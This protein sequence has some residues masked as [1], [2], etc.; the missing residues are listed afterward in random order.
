MI[1]QLCSTAHPPI[2]F[3]DSFLLLKR[4]DDH[5]DRPTSNR[6]RRDIEIEKIKV[7]SFQSLLSKRSSRFSK[8][9]FDFFCTKPATTTTAMTLTSYDRNTLLPS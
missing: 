3:I 6:A 4:E 8:I 9:G 2:Y 5:D 1:E 7:K